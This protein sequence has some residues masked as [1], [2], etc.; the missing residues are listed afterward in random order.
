MAALLSTSALSATII[1][2]PIRP[3]TVAPPPPA[4][5]IWQQLR[6]VLTAHPA[7]GVVVARMPAPAAVPPT[8]V[9]GVDGVD[10]GEVICGPWPNTTLSTST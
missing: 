3:P 2:F 9:D 8:A 5:D 6:D 4:P 10:G 1:A 7:D